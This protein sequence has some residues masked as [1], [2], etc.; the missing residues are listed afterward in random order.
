M[1]D[2]RPFDPGAPGAYID[3][4]AEDDESDVPLLQPMNNGSRNGDEF[5]V[6]DATR[7]RASTFPYP[8]NQGFAYRQDAQPLWGSPVQVISTPSLLPYSLQ[9]GPYY[10]QPYNLTTEPPYSGQVP[11]WVVSPHHLVT[12]GNQ[13]IISAAAHPYWNPGLGHGPFD[14]Q[15]RWQGR[16][17]IRKDFSPRR[18]ALCKT[19]LQ[20]QTRISPIK[21]RQENLP[22]TPTKS[23]APSKAPTN[24]PLQQNGLLSSTPQALEVRSAGNSLPQPLSRP[25]TLSEGQTTS[26]NVVCMQSPR[27]DQGGTSQGKLIVNLTNSNIVINVSA[28]QVFDEEQCDKILWL[29]LHGVPSRAI[30]WL[31]DIRTPAHTSRP[32]LVAGI[33]KLIKHFIPE[34]ATGQG[35]VEEPDALVDRLLRRGDELDW[36]GPYL[37]RRVIDFTSIPE[38]DIDRAR[39]ERQ[40]NARERRAHQ[41]WRIQH[42]EDPA[43]G[44]VQQRNQKVALALRGLAR[45]ADETEAAMEKFGYREGS[46]EAERPLMKKWLLKIRELGKLPDYL[47]EHGIVANDDQLA[48]ENVLS[49]PGT[50]TA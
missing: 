44:A 47:V 29:A 2:Q 10:Q 15:A 45:Y 5:R 30:S 14:L 33:D 1:E 34:L 26:S 24:A 43:E 17:P 35:H 41:K 48:A 16:P 49:A 28:R 6:P 50:M 19:T 20:G 39:K 38:E 3:L 32:T 8:G 23:V 27:N 9:A 40:K 4:T 18:P 42:D 37:L 13:N 46:H 12:T 25:R 7:S 36:S 31:I 22:P 11:R 21:K